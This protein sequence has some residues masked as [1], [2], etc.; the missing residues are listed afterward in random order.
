MTDIKPNE[1]I[2]LPPV[3]SWPQTVHVFDEKS[4]WA[5]RAAL[6]AQ[7]PLL[8]RGE[9]G[10]GKSQLARAAAHVL[11]RAFVCEV[12]HAGSECRELQWHFDAVGRLGEA[13]AIGVSGKAE[14]KEKMLDPLRFLS[15][16]ALWWAFD[17]ESAEE[18]FEKSSGGFRKP[19]KPRGWKP[20]DGCALLIDEI[21]K[22]DA[23]LPNGLLETLGNGA[24]AVPYMDESVGLAENAP[25]PLVVITTNEERELPSAFLRR[26]MVLRLKLPEKKDE[27]I[28]WLMEKGKLHFPD[29]PEKILKEAASQLWNDRKEALDQALPAPG[30]AEYLDILRA[31]D[32][33]GGDEKEQLKVLN[34]ISEFALQKYPEE[35]RP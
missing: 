25:P 20:Q 33:I 28:P 14:Y 22:A 15:P 26:C 9:P 34:E 13:Q 8:V 31:L 19:E 27:L 16:G 5:I 11:G 17:W 30:Q 10:T 32:E 4:A 12:V 24:F 21:D 23:D 29:C 3:G 6:A 1:K 2:N 7:R 18:Q 35:S